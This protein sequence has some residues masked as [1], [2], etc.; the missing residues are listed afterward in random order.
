MKN[1]VYQG[2]IARKRFGQNFLHDPFII[3]SI[4]AAINPQAGQTVV[5][6]GPGLG[7]LTFLVAKQL[8]RLC[9]IELDRDLAARL[10]N[11]PALA[12]K[13]TLFQQDALDIDYRQL[14][15]QLT[16]P[17][18][19]FGN[20]PY[21][22][23]TPLIFRLFSYTDV[24]ADMHFMLQ[25]EVV[26]RLL[27]LPGDTNYGRLSVMTQYHCQITSILEV[28]PASFSPA[29]KVD[30]EVVRLVPHASLPHPVPDLRLLSRLTALAF[31]QR[32][33]TI[34]NS[35]SALLAAGELQALG[36]NPALRA[37][38]ITLAQYSQIACYLAEKLSLQETLHE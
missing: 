36:V 34:R 31:N 26:D 30:S 25:K 29:P 14:A 38:N 10:Q 28:P 3:D 20:L 18:R 2:H 35:L 27:A 1:R 17:L 22:I 8:E 21:N 15:V 19:I 12:D 4:V 32:R 33:K 11:H 7:A 24:I 37:Q 6:I 5:E 23:S 16:A 9:L 13:I